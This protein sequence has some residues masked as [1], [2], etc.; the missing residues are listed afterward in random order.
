M[1]YKNEDLKRIRSFSHDSTRSSS[2]V[3]QYWNY[4]ENETQQNFVF[5]DICWLYVEYKC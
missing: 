3:N 1:C 5:V 2:K 4:N